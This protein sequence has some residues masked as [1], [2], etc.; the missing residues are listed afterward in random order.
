MALDANLLYVADSINARIRVLMVAP[1]SL[2]RPVG[3]PLG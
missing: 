1:P 3:R 2:E